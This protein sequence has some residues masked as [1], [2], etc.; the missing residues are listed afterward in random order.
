MACTVNEQGR[1][2]AIIIGKGPMGRS[3][4]GPYQAPSWE[5]DS[6]QLQSSHSEGNTEGEGPRHRDGSKTDF[7]VTF[8][9]V[10]PHTPSERRLVIA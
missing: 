5:E 8:Q 3:K 2:N 1:L 6:L 7:T 10:L 4:Q 9:G